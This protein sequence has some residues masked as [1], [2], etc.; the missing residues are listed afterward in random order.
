MS[1]LFGGDFF[2]WLNRIKTLEFYIFTNNC[3][4]IFITAMPLT[5]IQAIAFDADD[6]LWVNETL[7]REAEME[8]CVLMHD[9]LSEEKCNRLLFEM[10]MKNL[11]LYG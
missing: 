2:I 7:F 11:P 3:D 10:E 9:Y 8:F 4:K 5:K 1:H 6:T